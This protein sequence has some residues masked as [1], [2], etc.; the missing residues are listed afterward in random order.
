MTKE[1]LMAL[2]LSEEQAQS[3]L[4][5]YG[6][7]VPKSRLDDKIEE[8]KTANETIEAR[9]K[10]IKDLEPLAAGNQSL[11]EQIQ[12]LQADNQEAADKYAADL[13]QTKIASAIDLALTNAKVV[14]D[15]FSIAA[16]ALLDLDK[17]D[18]DKDGNVIGLE[19]QIKSLVE[20]DDTKAM[21][22][23]PEQTTL[24]GTNP[25]GGQQQQGNPVDTSKMTYSELK[26]YL[27]SNP[28]AQI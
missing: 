19:E 21:F 15:K 2:G 22:A 23:Q 24:A 13:K 28:D 4:D 5:G 6:K 10:Q 11:Q 8:L 12:K 27:E 1:Q 18:L 20:S 16:K 9:D 26:Q 3:V 14:N 17:V 25:A 7:M